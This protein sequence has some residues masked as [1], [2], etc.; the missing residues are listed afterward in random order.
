M[1][2]SLERILIALDWMLSQLRES[3]ENLSKPTIIN[4]SLG[5]KPEWL[6]AAHLQSVTDDLRMFFNHPDG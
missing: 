3:E 6:S 5:F 2:T 1:K 4:M